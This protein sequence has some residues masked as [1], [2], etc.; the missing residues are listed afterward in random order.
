MKMTAAIVLTILL[1]WGA[2]LWLPYWSLSLVAIAVGFGVNPGG[3]RALVSGLLGGGLL[4]GALAWQQKAANAGILA[5]RMGRLFGMDGN[6]LL[7]VTAGLGALLAGLALL[8]GD[9]AR[10]AVRELGSGHHQ[11]GLN[12]R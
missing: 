5:E 8:V 2:G 11:G 12:H 1:S 10:T 7:L 9:R 3:W 6:G 4:W